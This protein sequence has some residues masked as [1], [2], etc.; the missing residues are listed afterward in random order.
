M[1]GP[2]HASLTDT[3]ESHTVLIAC[4]HLDCLPCVLRPIWV[5]LTGSGQCF[6]VFRFE[7]CNTDYEVVKGKSELL[8]KCLFVSSYSG[9]TP[10]TSR[11]GYL[12]L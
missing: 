5:D 1:I 3:A 11:K 7:D 2:A 8:L 12:H 4:I 6:K 10:F 9:D